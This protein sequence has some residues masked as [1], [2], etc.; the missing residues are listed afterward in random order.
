MCAFV[1]KKSCAWRFRS[2]SDQIT[3]GDNGEIETDTLWR[4]V[5]AIHQ[6]LFTQNAEYMDGKL[7]NSGRGFRRRRALGEAW[8]KTIRASEA[9]KRLRRVVFPGRMR[10]SRDN[11]CVVSFTCDNISESEWNKR[12]MKNGASDSSRHS[13]L[14]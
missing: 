6:R 12:K 1:M 4:A 2:G 13:S 14:N 5:F 3:E 10:F 7:A 8:K 9:K 11:K